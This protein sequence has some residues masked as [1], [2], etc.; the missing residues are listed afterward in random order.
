MIQIKTPNGWSN[1]GGIRKTE[2]RKVISC[3]LGG[4]VLSGTPEHLI[5]ID[6][7]FIPLDSFESVCEFVA[8]VYDILEVELNNE[9][10]TDGVVSHN[11]H[12]RGSSNSLISG[13]VLEGMV[14]TKPIESE[15]DGAYRIYHEPI[16]NHSYVLVAD[17]S[18]GIG[19]DYHGVHVIDISTDPYEV[20]AVYHS[21]ELSHLLLPEVI[22][23]LAKSYNDALVLVENESTG[24]EVA[25]SLYDDY[26]YENVLMTTT[27]KGKQAI[28]FNYSKGRY[29]VKMS[30]SV[31]AI[32]CSNIKTMIERGKI[33]IND[34]A[35]IN[36]FGDFVPK[37][38]S[39]AAASGAHDDLVMPLVMFGW[40]STQTK[41]SELSDT[42][43]RNRF[44]KSLA[45]EYKTIPEFGFIDNGFS[46][47]DGERTVDYVDA[48]GFW[49]TE[50]LGRSVGEDFFDDGMT[51]F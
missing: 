31:K 37:G 45:D 20:S 46:V 36:E 50:Q 33:N 5:K 42:N 40:L 19:G 49:D 15:Q 32:G 29:G 6:D 41:F 23:K 48:D 21:N 28:T 12:F 7:Q 39:Y 2:N 11:C 24:S 22:Y 9:Y 27:E 13:R 16:P 26:E 38:G 47:F 35:T 14:V 51:G 1:F 10:Y 4:S 30:R 17:T 3:D 34:S 44:I 43:L 25:S 18:E 8:D